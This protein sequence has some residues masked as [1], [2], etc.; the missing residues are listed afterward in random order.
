MTDVS[1]NLFKGHG[2]SV[3][4]LFVEA[5][6][7]VDIRACPE[8]NCDLVFAENEFGMKAH[9]SPS[10]VSV[11]E[12]KFFCV[13]CTSAHQ[14]NFIIYALIEIVAFAIKT[15]LNTLVTFVMFYSKY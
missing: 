9:V 4:I 10:I 11:D 8:K 13:F 12:V 5:G 14:V 3:N 2:R 15:F 6:D 7:Y 1:L